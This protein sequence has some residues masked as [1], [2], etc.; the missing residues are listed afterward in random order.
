[1]STISVELLIITII[2]GVIL[3]FIFVTGKYERPS[4]I[5][6]SYALGTIINLNVCG[7]NGQK[8][9]EEAI[10]KLNDIDDKMSAFKE[11]SEI[12]KINFKAGATSEV[13]SRDT[14]FVI[15]KAV[16]YSK[17]LEGTFDP[18]IRPLLKLWNIG[19]EDEKIPEKHQIEE[20]LKLVNYND[21]ILDKSNFSIMLKN[22]KQA[23]DVG[24][25]AKGFAADEVRDI[26]Y[27]HNIKSALI[28]LGG[29]IFALGNKEDGTSWKVGIQNPFK[30]RG[31]HV[32]ILSVKN[33]SVVTSGN[34]ERYFI[35]DGKRFHHIIDPK[36]GYPSQSKII[37][38]TIISDNSIDGDGLST[39]VYILGIDKA[40]KIIEAIEGIDAIFITEDK[41]VYITSGIYKNIFTLTD[42]EFFLIDTTMKILVM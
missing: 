33:K 24:G 14:Y 9:I 17:I 8:A 36:T 35:K 34:Y 26:F 38:A 5:K 31:E 30:S 12:S 13:V 1:M 3:I 27:K 29:N 21:V 18:T 42:E 41:K 28:D 40:L 4:I 15:E 20:T 16:E 10:K 19:T 7:S 32:G 25:I 11:D 2:V 22:M 6:S 37:S 39:G 23:L